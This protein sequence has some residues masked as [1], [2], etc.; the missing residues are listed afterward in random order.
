MALQHLAADNSLP[1]DNVASVAAQC[2]V[3]PGENV[4]QCFK[5]EIESQVSKAVLSWLGT[6]KKGCRVWQGLYQAVVTST[7]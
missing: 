2:Q 4:L 7:D 3:H 5:I 6:T 1:V